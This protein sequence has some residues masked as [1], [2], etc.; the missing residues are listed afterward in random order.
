MVQR[1][2]LHPLALAAWLSLLGAPLASGDAHAHPSDRA[3]EHG[4][5][6]GKG[7]GQGQGQGQAR[8]RA[9]AW[10]WPRP[11]PGPGQKLLVI[12]TKKYKTFKSFSCFLVSKKYTPAIFS[13]F[14][15]DV[16]LRLFRIFSGF[17]PDV[18][19]DFF[20]NFFYEKM[21]WEYGNHE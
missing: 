21:G 7:Q 19:Y 5:G 3:H 9:W 10:V 1:T 4:K 17:F 14:F 16:F 12:K 8:A 20:G 18:F 6:E 2:R 11:G 15:P 13:G